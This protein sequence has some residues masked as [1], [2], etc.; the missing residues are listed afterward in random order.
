MFD[1]SLTYTTVF[2]S[3]SAPWLLVKAELSIVATSTEWE[4]E[5]GWKGGRGGDGRVLDHL[6]TLHHIVLLIPQDCYPTHL[7]GDKGVSHP[8]NNSDMSREWLIHAY[9]HGFPYLRTNQA[10]ATGRGVH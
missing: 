6:T 10:V 8:W 5:G 2:R 1:Q 4:L 7:G 3:L 9:I